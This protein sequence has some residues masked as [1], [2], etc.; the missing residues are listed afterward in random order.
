M[1]A[2]PVP[3]TTIA[4]IW[5]GAGAPGSARGRLRTI[6]G[7]GVAVDIDGELP[8]ERDAEV[9]VVAGEVGHRQVAKARYLLNRGNVAIFTVL[10]PF[11]PFDL[12]GQT[13]Y[14]V[15]AKTEVRSVLGHSRHP[16]QVLDISLGGLAV[17]V[18]SK[19]GGKMVEVPLQLYGYAATLPCEIVGTAGD[20]GHVILHL[21]FVGLTTTQ[22]AFVRNVVDHLQG[23]ISLSQAS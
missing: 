15:L 6:S 4:V 13:R 11:R 8:W 17:E 9:L 14:P 23:E 16:G 3:G 18:G 21:K 2:I 1:G 20:E 22:Q 12:R 5:R 10:A 19:P 7:D